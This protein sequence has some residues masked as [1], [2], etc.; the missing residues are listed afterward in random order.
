MQFLIASRS[1]PV[2]AKHIARIAVRGLA[3]PENASLSVFLT[4]SGASEITRV[5]FS[6]RVMRPPATRGRDP[7]PSG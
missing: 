3:D 2:Q 7:R 1:N 4:D 5:I 6:S